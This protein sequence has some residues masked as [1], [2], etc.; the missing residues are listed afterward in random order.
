MPKRNLLAALLVASVAL[1]VAPGAQAEPTPTQVATSTALFNEARSLM[2]MGRYDDAA[3]RLRG[4]QALTPG[5]GILLNLGECYEKTGRPASAFGSYSEAFVL[6]RRVGDDRATEAKRR[7]DA[8][9]PKLSRLK[10]DVAAANKGAGVVIT[11][12]GHELPESVWSSGIP[13]DPGEHTIE[14]KAPRKRAWKTVVRVEATP[15]TTPVVVPALETDPGAVDD[16]GRPF[17]GAQRIAGASAAGLGV[18]GVVVGSIFGAL[19]LQKASASKSNGHCDADLKSCDAMGLQ[20]QQDAHTT[21]HV[22]TAGLAV[23]GAALAAGVIL[24]ATAPSASGAPAPKTG[25]RVT[26]GPMAGAGLSG[27]LIRGD[28]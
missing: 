4:A 18:A 8:V 20:L 9:E 28:W 13:V 22:S 14:A 26:I 16:A 5:V 24:F 25:A 12:D 2:A 27:V 23:G 1:A 6:A 15:A 17:W 10:L 11:Q 3:Q 7:Q 19:T 21:A